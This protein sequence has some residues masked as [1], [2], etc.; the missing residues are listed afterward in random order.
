VFGGE[1]AAITRWRLD[2]SGP[3][4]ERI[5]DGY[6]AADR[7]GYDGDETLLVARRPHGARHSAD[8]TDYALWDAGEDRMLDDILPDQEEGIEGIGW[9]G[10]GLLSGMDVS[11]LQFGWYDT[12]RRALVDGPP[13]GVECD[14]LW[15]S[16]EGT[17]GYCGGPGGQVWTIDVDSRTLVGPTMRV[18]GGV[19]SVSAT[20]GGER[21]VVTSATE[22]G[23][24]TVV[25]DATGR[26]LAGPSPGP[27][28]MSVSLDGTLMGT[29]GGAITRYNLET[30]EPLGELAG[31]KGEVNTLQFSDDGS[32]LL[33]TSN[34]QTAS[35]YDVATGTRLGDPIPTGAPFIYPAYIK[36]DGT[37]LVITDATGIVRWDLQPDHLAEAACRV[38][39]RN[40]TR[41]EWSTYVADLGEYR[42]TCGDELLAK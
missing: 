17:R 11:A 5:A 20:R 22:T 36:P 4:S 8:F 10:R 33:A 24:E 16:A 30:L 39:G 18:N 29:S 23:F 6:V 35:L 27:L 13:I 42:E 25:F 3:V 7:F 41:T 9:V 2:G 34:D 14:H 12:D 15:P 26:V 31:A 38:A 40:F 21:V 1:S 32:L 28:L 19:W 37:A